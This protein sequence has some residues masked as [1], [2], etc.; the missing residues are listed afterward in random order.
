LYA[1]DEQPPSIMCGVKKCLGCEILLYWT[2]EEFVGYTLN[3]KSKEPT[4]K[5]TKCPAEIQ[6]EVTLMFKSVVF[7]KCNEIKKFA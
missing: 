7:E 2:T 3:P 6:W 5:S 4:N 1:C